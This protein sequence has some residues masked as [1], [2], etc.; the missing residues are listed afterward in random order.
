MSENINTVIEFP[1]IAERLRGAFPR[2]V[3]A[4]VDAILGYIPVTHLEPTRW[5]IGSVNIIGDPVYIPSRIY[6][7][8][9]VEINSDVITHADLSILACLYTRHHNGFVRQKYIEYLFEFD[10][11]WIPPFV[12]NLVGEYVVEIIE[13]IY[14]KI[15]RLPVDV[16]KAFINENPAFIQLIKKR[17]I[18]YWNCYYRTPHFK[19]YVGYKVADALG[20]WDKNDIKHLLLSSNRR[21]RP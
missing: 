21:Q 5:D 7:P 11:A 4:N 18:S 15:D 3:R 2:S 17:I 13:V 8:E 1:E 9:P 12:L 16:F 20:L 14:R 19:D 6:F 10:D